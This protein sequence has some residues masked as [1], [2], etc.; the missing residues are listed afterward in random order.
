MSSTL[1][2]EPVSAVMDRG[3]ARRG[4]GRTSTS[5]EFSSTPLVLALRAEQV[6]PSRSDPGGPTAIHGRA[7]DAYLAKAATAL[8][9][10]MCCLCS[11]PRS[12]FARI[13]SMQMGN[14]MM[15]AYATALRRIWPPPSSIEPSTTL[16][17]PD[18]PALTRTGAPSAAR[19]VSCRAAE[20]AVLRVSQRRGH[21]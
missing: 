7:C 4:P 19:M 21:S 5:V 10:V 15:D 17:S 18:A 16:T 12:R 20:H 13:F 1:P 14:P 9:P 11:P 6:R 2:A 3:P 8:M